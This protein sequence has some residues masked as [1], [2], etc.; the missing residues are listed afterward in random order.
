MGSQTKAWIGD[1]RDYKQILRLDRETDDQFVIYEL[2]NDYETGS[3]EPKYLFFVDFPDQSPYWQTLFR[4][5]VL[6]AYSVIQA[7]GEFERLD[8]PGCIITRDKH[9]LRVLQE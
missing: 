1:F 5:A 9:K 3:T 8:Y 7:G 2:Y 6:S 4:T